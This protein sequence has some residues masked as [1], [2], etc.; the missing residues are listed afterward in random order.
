M[1]LSFAGILEPYLPALIVVDGAG[2]IQDATSRANSHFPQL[3]TGRTL[4]DVFPAWPEEP[5]AGIGR[6]TLLR[7]DGSRLFAHVSARGDMFV[8]SFDFPFYQ[9]VSGDRSGD[10]LR[11]IIDTIPVG[12]YEFNLGGKFVYANEAACRMFGYDPE[13]GPIGKVNVMDVIVPEDKDKAVLRIANVIQ[14]GGV[15]VAE[16]TAVRRDGSRFPLE[17][18]SSLVVRG[19]K[20]D[21]MRGILIDLTEKKRA[22]DELLKTNRLESLGVLAGG[23]AHDFNNI[24]TVIIGNISLAKFDM[25]RDAESF[26]LLDDA[27]SA[28]LR[29]QSLTRQLLVFSK[30]G[31]PVKENSDIAEIVR[32]SAAFVLSGSNAVCRYQFP[33]DLWAASV[34]RGQFSRVI[35]N[36]VLNAAQA[37][38]GGGTITI[39]GENLRVTVNDTLPLKFGKYVRITISDTGVGI[40]H[41]NQERV[42]DPYFSTK[43][44]GSGLGLSVAYSIVRSHGGH[45]SIVSEPGR[46]TDILVYVPATTEQP[47]PGQEDEAA[48]DLAQ[49][50]VLVVDDEEQIR[51][52]AVEMLRL[53]GHDALGV[54]SGAEA[55]EAYAGSIRAGNPYELA[56]V[57][58]TIPGDIPTAELVERLRDL[59]GIRLALVSGYLSASDSPESSSRGFDYSLKKPFT[60]EELLAL[61]KE[62]TQD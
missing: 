52:I 6:F 7:E 16:Y 14:S 19:G 1:D 49:L 41:E 34:D 8:I 61:L 36:I 58:L 33:A 26:Q 30:G 13:D 39:S 24:L 25:S 57:D 62:M 27:E 47:Q 44:D 43:D 56:L 3:A 4:R 37:M 50:R 20:P 2:I 29:A 38:P 15:S 28:A 31:E 10:E 21:G 53:A 42:F 59:G 5:L 54:K 18:H 46:G 32:Q 11:S 51:K 22:E 23:I 12:V 9:E 45:I 35:Q 40:P 48:G 17:V 60:M 55:I